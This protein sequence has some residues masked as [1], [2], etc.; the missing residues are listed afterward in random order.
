MK[1]AYPAV[2]SSPRRLGYRRRL[3][4]QLRYHSLNATTRFNGTTRERR[5]QSDFERM[6]GGA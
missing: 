1:R 6:S 5:K 3:V 2:G 4:G